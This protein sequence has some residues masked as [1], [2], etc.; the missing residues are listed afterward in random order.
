VD[1]LACRSQRP[2]RDSQGCIQGKIVRGNGSTDL[3]GPDEVFVKDPGS[4]TPWYLHAE[5]SPRR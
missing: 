1:V 4:T 5:C 2:V 3:V